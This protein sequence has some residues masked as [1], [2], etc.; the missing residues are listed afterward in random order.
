[1]FLSF[2]I[3]FSAVISVMLSFTLIT[4]VTNSTNTFVEKYRFSSSDSIHVWKTFLT[5]PSYMG[6]VTHK[7]RFAHLRSIS[8]STNKYPALISRVGQ[9][10]IR[11]QQ[12]PYISIPYCHNSNNNLAANLPFDDKTWEIFPHVLGLRTAYA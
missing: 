12:C 3:S 5:Y 2:Q 8:A 10:S 1:M 6:D 4:T 11:C 9:Q 7:H